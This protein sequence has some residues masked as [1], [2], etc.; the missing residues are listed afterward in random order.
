MPKYFRYF[1]ENAEIILMIFGHMQEKKIFFYLGF[2]WQK[3]FF[4]KTKIGKI[5]L[6][7]CLSN[8]PL[9]HTFFYQNFG[10]PNKALPINPTLT[11]KLWFDHKQNQSPLL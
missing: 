11:Q 1:L 9:N 8:I 7:G 5:V 3:L 2:V 10:K 4:C 6:R